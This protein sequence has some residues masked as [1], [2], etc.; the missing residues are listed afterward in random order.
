MTRDN[1]LWNVNFLE[2]KKKILKERALALARQPQN[3]EK[4]VCIEIIKFQLANEYYAIESTYVREVLPLRELTPLPCTPSFVLGVIN[5]RGQIVSVIDFKRFFNLPANGVLEFK[6]VIILQTPEME[7]GI[8]V[9]A[10]IGVQPV[11]V[12]EIQPSLPTLTGISAEYLKG[13]TDDPLV[14]LDG[15]KILS[16]KKLIVN[17]EVEG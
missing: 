15:F 8:P 4:E 16:D 7:L 3:Q 6:E 2:K 11:P 9:D 13:V 17:E 1:K 12:K 5:V 10:V 14:I